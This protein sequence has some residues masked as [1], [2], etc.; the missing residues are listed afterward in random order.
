MRDDGSEVHCFLFS[1]EEEWRGRRT[2]PG[3][4]MFETRV[5]L[6]Y[7]NCSGLE[8]GSKGRKRKVRRNSR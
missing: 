7:S 5:S 8:I 2:N 1:G 6:H 3:A 4:K